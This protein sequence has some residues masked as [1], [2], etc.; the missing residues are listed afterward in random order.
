MTRLSKV[1]AVILALL[2]LPMVSHCTWEHLSGL[3]FLGCCTSAE[4]EPNQA[5]D[6]QTDLCASVESGH[7]KLEEQ[8]V[9]APAPALVEAFL[10][11]MLTAVPKNPPASFVA[12]TS[13]PP[14]L[15]QRWQ[16]AFR[17]AAP[18]RAPSFVS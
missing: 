12:S 17:A 4:A 6:C 18:T 2:W 11:P 3:E 15:P 7:Y 13:I 9:A 14:E 8:A 10:I 16:F 5:D 1:M